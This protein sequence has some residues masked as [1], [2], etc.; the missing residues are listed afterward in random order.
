MPCI[1]H[2]SMPHAATLLRFLNSTR[3]FRFHAT[4]GY[5]IPIS[6]QHQNIQISTPHAATLFQYLN[7]TRRFRPP[8]HRP[9]NNSKFQRQQP[10]F[11]TTSPTGELALVSSLFRIFVATT[12]SRVLVSVKVKTE[13]KPEVSTQLLRWTLIWCKSPCTINW[14]RIA[15]PPPSSAC[16]AQSMTHKRHRISLF[17]SDKSCDVATQ[18]VKHY[19][20]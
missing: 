20:T 12:P 3:R 13:Q 8:P 11:P 6:Q 1:A 10:L 9:P 17:A 18:V 14:T 5:T 15:L 16:Q 19:S 4:C 2:H 7:S